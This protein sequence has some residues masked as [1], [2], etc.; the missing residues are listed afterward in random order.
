MKSKCIREKTML[1]LQR[2]SF[3]VSLT[4]SSLFE[5]V[6]R[7]TSLI[8]FSQSILCNSYTNTLQVLS[9]M[10]MA[11]HSVCNV[12][13]AHAPKTCAQFK[14]RKYYIFAN[15]SMHFIMFLLRV[16]CLLNTHTDTHA[17]ICNVHTESLNDPMGAKELL[18]SYAIPQCVCVF[19]YIVF[20]GVS[21]CIHTLSSILLIPFSQNAF[22]IDSRVHTHTH[23]DS[24]CSLFIKRL[25]L[26]GYRKL[27]I[28]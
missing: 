21:L 18:Y 9:G 25:T 7:I 24:L 1:F 14:I 15:Y 2:S 26:I 27:Y 12:A 19:E 10:A 23:I 22:S 17:H 5:I 11:Q 4:L 28:L 8:Y 13:I 3:R 20:F 6:S 16:F